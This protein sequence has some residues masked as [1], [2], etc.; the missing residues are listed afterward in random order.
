MCPMPL[1]A[2]RQA[3]LLGGVGVGWDQKPPQRKAALGG[4]QSLFNFQGIDFS[5]ARNLKRWIL[6]VAVLGNSA[7]N[8]MKRGYL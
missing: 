7:T 1:M 2:A 3:D 8:S 4:A 5:R 6:P